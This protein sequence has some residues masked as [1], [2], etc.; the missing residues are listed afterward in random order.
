[1]H[2]AEGDLAV[3][4][5]LRQ[6]KKYLLGGEFVLRTDHRSLQ[7]IRTLPQ[8]SAAVARHLDFMSQF[9]SQIEY[10]PAINT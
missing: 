10:R 2:Y 4:F 5:A 9:D 8:V 3:I 1:M 6:F 7:Y